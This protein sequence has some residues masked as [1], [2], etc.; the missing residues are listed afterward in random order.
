MKQAVTLFQELSHNDVDWLLAN[1]SEGQLEAN[2]TLI[3]A[4]NAVD[5]IHLV[6]QGVLS[7]STP[8]TAEELAILGPGDLVG[9]M[10]FLEQEPATESVTAT[11]RT[12]TLILPHALLHDRCRDD[13][14]FSARLHRSLGRILSRRLRR[15]NR[16][17]AVQEGADAAVG[18]EHPA[19]HRLGE[20]IGDFKAI[21]HEANEVAVK[22]GTS[23]PHDVADEI[24]AQF[25]DFYAFMNQVFETEL[26]NERVRD[27]VGLLAQREFL[28]Y[29]L[30]AEASQRFYTKPRGYAGDYWT[31]ELVYRNE[32]TGSSPLGVLV[33]RCLL[34]SPTGDAVRNRRGL[35]AEEIR[36]AVESRQNGPTRITS[37]ACGPA[38]EVFDVLADQED[39]DRLH[40]TLLDIDTQALAF[41]E[42]TAGRKG[43]EAAISLV[44]ANLIHLALGRAE[45]DIADQDLVYSIGLIDYLDDDLVVRLMS[46]IHGMLRPGGRV[47]LGNFHP[48]NPV[49]AFMDHVLDWRL[50][51]R[52]EE[53]MDR[54][55]RK[56]A[57]GRPTSNVRFEA[58][59]INLFAECVRE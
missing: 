7:V 56:S 21:V 16:R 43:L 20:K 50:V 23:I 17:L 46:L 49:R 35:L 25:R 5:A 57:F 12:A 36:K 14:G 10:S 52:S 1:A 54:L 45:T 51:H 4:G 19:W 55:F 15:A 34:E 22:E 47:I 30:L 59:E 42:E 8:E 27:G 40:A 3:E 18:A 58:Q 44:P 53:D 11:E 33:D 9:E 41:V 29:L 2:E 24:V 32:P 26:P 38:R 31:I 13:P 37:L 39:A 6:V 28:P 48:R